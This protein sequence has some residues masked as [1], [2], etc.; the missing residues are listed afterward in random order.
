MTDAIARLVG[1][2]RANEFDAVQGDSA[3]VSADPHPRLAGYRVTD[4]SALAG[5]LVW[6]GALGV[7]G[8]TALALST[9]DLFVSLAVLVLV[10][11]GLGLAA[12]P[13][14]SGGVVLPYRL[15][16]AGQ[17][18][19]AVAVVAAL[20]LPVGSTESVALVLPWL[21]VTGLVALV[22]LWRL[23][24]RGFLP[25]AELTVDAALFYVPVGAVALV[26]HRAG[27]S[28]R[29]EPIIVLLT[30]VHYHYAGFVLPLVTGLVDRRLA[31]PDGRFGTDLAGRVAVAATLVIVVNLALI[32]V[33]ITFSPL[34]E[35]VAVALFTVAVAGFALLTLAKVVPAV[36]GLPAAGLAV[37]S[38]AIVATMALALGYG[39]SA[40]PATGEVISIGE[41]IRWHGTLN[42][43]GFALPALLAFRRL[44]R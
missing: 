42:A 2:Q 27:I 23:L 6:L 22:G 18:P 21:G 14:R 41:M 4:L 12:T 5:A 3:S 36:D 38:L 20:A 17:L 35:V 11:L 26:L 25:V 13:R 24:S 10:P 34:V 40:F 7:A 31:G 30:V 32:A 8:T 39:Y 43:F 44:E 29:F 28:L 9:V 15:A 16:V 33:G 19:A 1:E 37:A